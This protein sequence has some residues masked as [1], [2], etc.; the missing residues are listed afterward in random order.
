MNQRNPFLF[1]LI[2]LF[3]ASFTGAGAF[4]AEAPYR[5]IKEIPIGGEGG[6]DYLSVDASARRLY[7]THASTVVV[8]DLVK[9]A[10]MGVITNTPGVHGFA[11]APELQRGF[12][13]NGRESTVSIVDLTSLR[14]LAK[15]PAGENPDAILY[16]PG[17]REVYSFNGR[18]HS[19]TVFAAASTNVIA[20]IVLPGTPEFAAADPEAGRV[21][22]NIEDY[23]EVV[24][25]DTRTHQIVSAWPTAPGEE[26]AGMAIDLAHHRLFIGC[27]NKRM[28]MM[29]SA[30]GSVL[31]AAPIGQGVDANVFDPGT[32][33]VFSSCGEGNVTIARE[34]LQGTLTVVQ[35][36]ATERSARTMALDPATHRIYL[37]SAQF[38]PQPEA[39]PGTP[40]PRPTIIPGSMKI[41][42]Y[43]MKPHDRP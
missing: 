26:P 8:V 6:W 3:C 5:L 13:S 1:G 22:C 42:V 21:Y 24:A 38:E 14:T 30:N 23:N 9:D 2:A 34:D 27:H 36:L 35:T 7:V 39:A 4:G 28:V 12:A 37:A 17:R 29:D 41:L 16:E 11:L 20:T 31:A 19:A 43:G 18:A 15:V 32:R 10:V 25:I 40:R 33:L